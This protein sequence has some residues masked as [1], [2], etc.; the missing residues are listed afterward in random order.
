MTKAIDPF[1]EYLR[2]KKVEMMEQKLRD[3]SG[4]KPA[5]KSEEPVEVD[6]DEDP[7]ASA[8]LS[9]EMADFFESGQQAGA[10][11]F[12]QMQSIEEDKVEEIKDA[13]DEVFEED[14]PV[15]QT[16]ENE[17]NFVEFFQQV[18]TEFDAVPGDRP[19]PVTAEQP[20]AE[21]PA[22]SLPKPKPQPTPPQSRPAAP[23]PVEQVNVTVDV[24]DL[25]RPG[26]LEVSPLALA[27]SDDLDLAS[28]REDGRLNLATILLNKESGADL[29]Q[30]VEVLCRIVSR[31]VEKAQLPESEIIEALIKADVEF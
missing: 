6:P 4:E 15:P 20:P 28:L 12:N 26:D 14:A 7:E 31:L 3:P 10:E 18:E 11:L 8:R 19:R 21:P 29:E 27:E 22:P 9:E 16:E 1:E 30:Q 13:L 5:P 17:N 25:P 24:E 23:P 2:K